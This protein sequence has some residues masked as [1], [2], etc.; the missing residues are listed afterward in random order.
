MNQ[1]LKKQR[2]WQKGVGLV[3]IAIALVV[4]G[5]LIGAALQG[6]HLIDQARLNAVITDVQKIRINIQKFKE[7]YG[8]LPG[9]FPYASRDINASL[10]NGDGSGT[11][12]GNPFLVSSS[13][14]RF[15]AHLNAA[16]GMIPPS[17]ST[18]NYGDGLISCG[19][20]GGYT[21]V[22]N[23]LEDMSGLWIVLGSKANDS[24]GEGP[25]LT[26]EQAQYINKKMD[27]GAP[28]TGN[29]RSLDADR[30]TTGKCIIDGRYNLS[31]SEKA[32]VM[33]FN[34]DES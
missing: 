16:E 19:L 32:C 22:S 6:K 4:I 2:R 11:L 27:N 14:G 18:L 29:V 3:E 21:I 5:I 30:K 15:W 10:S 26:P 8:F 12:S 24:S 7:K 25:L 9:D 28:L 23:P 34:I 20:G 33:Y 31:T 17:S 1:I 13:N